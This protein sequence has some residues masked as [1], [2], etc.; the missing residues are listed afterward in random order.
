M[1][2]RRAVL[3]LS[4]GTPALPGR[5]DGAFGLADIRAPIY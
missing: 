5:R 3:S 1:T 2:T 4:V